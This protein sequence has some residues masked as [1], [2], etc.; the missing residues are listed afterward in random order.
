MS[1][2]YPRGPHVVIIVLTSGRGRRLSASGGFQG[3]TLLALKMEEAGHE[4]GMQL[5]E[6]R[7]AECNP[8]LL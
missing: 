7:K 6:V 4:P 3:A 8:S 5:L 1:L 2:D